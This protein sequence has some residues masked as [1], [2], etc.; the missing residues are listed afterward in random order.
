MNE[1]NLTLTTFQTFYLFH[2]NVLCVNDFI[3]STPQFPVVSD[4]SFL[5]TTTKYNMSDFSHLWKCLF[6]LYILRAKQE[7]GL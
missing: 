7:K 2:N 4:T 6:L 3:L 5:G 1:N